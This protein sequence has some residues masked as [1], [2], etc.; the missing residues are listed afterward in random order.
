MLHTPINRLIKLFSLL[1]FNKELLH[2]LNMYSKLSFINIKYYNCDL[3]SVEARPVTTS[4]YLTESV[5][6]HREMEES[7]LREYLKAKESEVNQMWN[8]PAWPGPKASSIS[9]NF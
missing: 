6:R 9:M 2:Y 1:E 4:S 7:K 8:K 5:Q 3:Q